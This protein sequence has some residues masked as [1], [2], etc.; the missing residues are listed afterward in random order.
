MGKRVFLVAAIVLATVPVSAVTTKDSGAGL[1]ADQL[2]QA[3][4]GGGITITNVKVTGAPNAIGT[5]SGGLADGLSIDGGV[6][7]S[8]GDINTAAG[9]NT[10]EGTTASLGTD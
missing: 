2:A 10:N 7:M 3:L 5:F 9:P 8:S 1:T 4:T 6:I